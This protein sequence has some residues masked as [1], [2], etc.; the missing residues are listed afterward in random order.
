MLVDIFGSKTFE[1]LFQS[2]LKLGKFDKMT[3]EV[4]KLTN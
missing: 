2:G 1:P 4:H 3:H